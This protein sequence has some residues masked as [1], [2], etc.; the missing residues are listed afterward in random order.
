MQAIANEL[1]VEIRD[2][3]RT[4]LSWLVPLVVG[5]MGASIALVARAG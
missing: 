3:T 1:C 5:G 4:F 2:R